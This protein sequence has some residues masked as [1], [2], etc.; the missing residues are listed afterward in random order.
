MWS[1][2]VQGEVFEVDDCIQ[3]RRGINK[4]KIPLDLW[5]SM[6]H[7]DDVESAMKKFTSLCVQEDGIEEG[8]IE[9]QLWI[10]LF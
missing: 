8:T 7:K 10:K 5:K 6:I 3:Q 9:F 2:D 1:Y 4:E